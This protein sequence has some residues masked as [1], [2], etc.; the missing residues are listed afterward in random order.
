MIVLSV[1]P[2]WAFARRFTLA[3][4]TDQAIG[5]IGFTTNG[6]APNVALDT[7]RED[8]IVRDNYSIE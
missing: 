2:H 4:M 6:A 7:A 1:L 8:Q 3:Y 5:L